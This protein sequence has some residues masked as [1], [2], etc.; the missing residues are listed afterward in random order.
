M[1]N[2][3]LR[4][5]I[6]TS[7]IN[8]P[9]FTGDDNTLGVNKFL[10]LIDTL[11][12]TK[13]ISDE[14]R[15]IEILKENIDPEKGRVRFIINFHQMEEINQ[16]EAYKKAFIKHFMSKCDQDPIRSLVKM[17]KELR[18]SESDTEYLARLDRWSKDMNSILKDS[19]W[20][21]KSSDKMKVSQVIKLFTFG[22][23]TKN[24]DD[25]TAEKLYKDLKSNMNLG[26][27]DYLM[28]GYSE[29]RLN[30]YVLTVRKQ[31]N[32]PLEFKKTKSRDANII[33]FNCD[34]WGHKAQDCYYGL[35]CRNCKYEGH[36]EYQCRNPP[37]CMYH[38]RI[39]HK[40]HECRNFHMRQET[41]GKPPDIE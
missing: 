29:T 2:G 11:L 25:L 1:N 20:V 23:L 5:E 28:Q 22:L 36:D 38:Q 37:F 3:V 15:K 30:P 18:T 16:Y 9:K 26:E 8:I 21:E 6:H 7:N 12:V 35:I 27:V 32:S 13:N 19:D 40:T 41:K 33:C 31:R 14:K 39:G 4:H 17:I 24:S 10:N 34:S